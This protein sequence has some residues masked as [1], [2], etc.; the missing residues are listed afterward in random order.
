MALLAQLGNRCSRK[1]SNG[2][3][4]CRQEVRGV[5]EDSQDSAFFDSS[6]RSPLNSAI[7]ISTLGVSSIN[8]SRLRIGST[9]SLS[10]SILKRIFLDGVKPALS[11]ICL[12][13]NSSPLEPT[14]PSDDSTIT[15][16]KTSCQKFISYSGERSEERRV[17]KE[18]R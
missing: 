12:G 18:C 9:M 3:S 14:R 2:D 6:R 5:R 17:G 10:S 16:N 11:L 13:G 8:S 15:R 4:Y 1:A 7:D